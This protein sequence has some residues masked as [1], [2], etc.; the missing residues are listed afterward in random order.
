MLLS[1]AKT[2]GRCPPPPSLERDVSL[3]GVNLSR[4][5]SWLWMERHRKVSTYLERV[6][7]IFVRGDFFFFF[8][9]VDSGGKKT[10]LLGA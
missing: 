4:N 10:I 2:S 3:K 7:W 1:M 9:A 8:D 5:Y 6:V